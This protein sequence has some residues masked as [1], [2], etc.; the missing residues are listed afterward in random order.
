MSDGEILAYLIAAFCQ[1]LIVWFVIAAYMQLATA[2]IENG[3]SWPVER[4]RMKL[5]APAILILVLHAAFPSIALAILFVACI[6]RPE[7]RFFVSL[8]GATSFFGLIVVS[9][10]VRSM[11]PSRMA[12]Y[13]ITNGVIGFLCLI[14]PLFS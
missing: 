13:A 4:F 14:I 5:G 8:T 1:L 11:R 6:V 7:L 2:W 9:L 12:I 10:I 3:W